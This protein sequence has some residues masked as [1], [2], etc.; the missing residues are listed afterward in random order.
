[1]FHCLRDYSTYN[2]HVE[3]FAGPRLTVYSKR[4][5]NNVWQPLTFTDRLNVF[6]QP[7]LP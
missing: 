2:L 5:A 4:E 3:M 6:G 7:L 1:M